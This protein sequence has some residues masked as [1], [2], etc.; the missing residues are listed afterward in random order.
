LKQRQHWTIA[1]LSG[2]AVTVILSGQR[3]NVLLLAVGLFA[4]SSLWSWRT[5]LIGAAALVAI[6]VAVHPFAPTLQ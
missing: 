5:R 1:L 3:N 4:L 2:I 6:L